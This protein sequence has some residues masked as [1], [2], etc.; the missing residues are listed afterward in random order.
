MKED[1]YMYAD[2]QGS[3]SFGGRSPKWAKATSFLWSGG[4]GG[5][6]SAGML[7]GNVLKIITCFDAIWCILRHNLV[8]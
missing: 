8:I 6:C 2:S 7:P 1:S 5:R 3:L 4:A